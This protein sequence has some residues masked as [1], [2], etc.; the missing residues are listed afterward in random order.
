MRAVL[1][2]T[3]L[4]LVGVAYGAL[5]QD[6]CSNIRLSVAEQI[7][8]RARITNALGDSDRTRIQQ[9]F[10]SRVRRANDQLI[11]PPVLTS[12]QPGRVTTLPSTAPPIVPPPPVPPRA[13]PAPGA[14]SWG[15]TAPGSTI[16]S[17]SGVPNESI[18]QPGGPVPGG[19]AVVPD[20]RVP[21]PNPTPIPPLAPFSA[22]PGARS[23]PSP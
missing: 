5:A 16:P 8:C 7:D 2:W 20:L 17:S 1:G 14:S 23:S 10:E 21:D 22:N 12:P 18:T 19:N 6:V 3:A 15:Q 11:T 13:P 9:E 4:G